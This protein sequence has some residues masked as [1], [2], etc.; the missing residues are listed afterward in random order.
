MKKRN[1]DR[2]VP[3]VKKKIIC[4]KEWGSEHLPNTYTATDIATD[5]ATD[6]ATNTATDTTTDT[7]THLVEFA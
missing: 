4:N 7:A 5:T 2:V 1:R 3:S 6:T